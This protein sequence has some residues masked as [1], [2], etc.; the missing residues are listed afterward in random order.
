MAFDFHLIADDDGKWNCTAVAPDGST[1]PAIHL[2]SALLG[3][4]Q[5]FTGVAAQGGRLATVSEVAAQ[6]A[7]PPTE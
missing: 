5:H 7:E 1:V 6:T 4:A 3:A 2:V